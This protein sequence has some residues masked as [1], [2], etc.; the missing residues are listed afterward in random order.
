MYYLSSTWPLPFIR[1]TIDKRGTSTLQTQ[2]NNNTL[3]CFPA[4]HL[5]YSKPRPRLPTREHCE[6]STLRKTG[7]TALLNE[8]EGM[9]KREKAAKNYCAA[10]SIY[11]HTVKSTAGFYFGC[12]YHFG[13]LTWAPLEAINFKPQSLLPVH[14]LTFPPP[15]KE[16][17]VEER[18]E[19]RKKGKE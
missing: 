12:F 11:A 18:R 7:L 19:E 5:H 13:S 8:T 6:P 16:G 17:R 3:C 10:S 9:T 14:R 4:A 15:L 1:A 2:L